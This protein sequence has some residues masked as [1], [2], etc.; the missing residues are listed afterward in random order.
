MRGEGISGGEPVV[1]AAV[2]YDDRSGVYASVS[3]TEM[4]GNDGPRF[5]GLDG[6]IGYAARIAPSVSL[7]GGIHRAHYRA[8]YP[9]GRTMRYT[10]AYA[11]VS[12]NGVSARIFYSPDYLADNVSTFYGELDATLQPAPDWRVSAHVGLLAYAD[13]EPS[14]RYGYPVSRDTRYDWRLG[15]SRRFGRFEVHAA[16]SGGGPGN[17]YYSYSND[18]RD[19]TAFTAGAS[20]SL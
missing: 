15:A 4:V 9:G 8:P 10:E 5:L 12:S 13:G 17:A 2:S 3:A 19:R 14:Y 11:G 6:A 18:R 20:W 7:E 1:T 16:V